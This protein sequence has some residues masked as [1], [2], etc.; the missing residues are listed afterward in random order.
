MVSAKIA[1]LAVLGFSATT[2]A[3]IYPDVDPCNPAPPLEGEYQGEYDTRQRVDSARCACQIPGPAPSETL[4]EYNER[5]RIDRGRCRVQII[6]PAW[7][8]PPAI[9]Y[10]GPL[11]GGPIIVGGVS[12]RNRDHWRDPRW[13]RGRPEPVR[14]RPEPGRGR[15]EPGRG[16]PE[17][18]RGRPEPVRGRPGPARGRPEPAR[19]RPRPEPVRG[20]K[21]RGGRP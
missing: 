15:P 18:G 20:G 5:N 19:G 13:G 14:G 21:G 6:V 9:T 12:W 11:V 10:L 17:P 8:P 7:S 3:N 1:L 2:F 4:D 16:R